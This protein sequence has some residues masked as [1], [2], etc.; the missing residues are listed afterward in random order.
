MNKGIAFTLAETLIVLSIIGVVAALSLPNLNASTQNLQKV[1]Q[2]RK[3]YA[4]LSEAYGRA[5]ATYGPLGTWKNSCEVADNNVCFADRL[6]ESLK[7]SKVCGTTFGA[8]IGTYPYVG[9]GNSSALADY[10]NYSFLLSNGMGILVGPAGNGEN[11]TISF[12]NCINSENNCATITVDIDGPNKGEKR[13]GTDFFYFSVYNTEIRPF[14][15]DRSLTSCS[16]NTLTTN[17]VIENGNMDYLK[18]TCSS[19][20]LICPNGKTLGYDTTSGEVTS[21]K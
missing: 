16:W 1:T 12:D 4:T 21:C 14:G 9:E 7:V 10:G 18:A 5:I 6:M 8:C 20:K 11:K 19:N 17:W 15:F 2:L 13:V 3:V